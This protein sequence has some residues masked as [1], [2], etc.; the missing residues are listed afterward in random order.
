MTKS[1]VL[2]SDFINF[3][4]AKHSSSGFQNFE[5]VREPLAMEKRLK[6][7]IQKK[8]FQFF[9]DFWRIFFFVSG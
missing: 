8:Y 7:F 5:N 2:D 9:F 3:H 6:K 1:N 4:G